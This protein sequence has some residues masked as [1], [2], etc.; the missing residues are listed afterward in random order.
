MT[1]FQYFCCLYVVCCKKPCFMEDSAW[2]VVI[3]QEINRFSRFLIWTFRA[4]QWRERVRQDTNSFVGC[5]V[6]VAC[7][8]PLKVSPYF[9]KFGFTAFGTPLLWY[10]SSRNQKKIPV[11]LLNLQGWSMMRKS[12][13][14]YQLVCWMCCLCCLCWPSK[15]QPIFW[16]FRFRAFEL[17]IMGSHP[18]LRTH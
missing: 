16:K 9:W 14:I 2:I 15:S 5:V 8:D 1:L 18:Y 4:D 3:L 17:L 13:T 10:S 11:S 7:A 6:G 12:Q